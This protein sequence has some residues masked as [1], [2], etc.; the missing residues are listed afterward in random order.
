MQPDLFVNHSMMSV[1]ANPAHAGLY[2]QMFPA[3]PLKTSAQPE[4]VQNLQQYDRM[5]CISSYTQR[6]TAA[7]WDYPPEKMHVLLPPI[8]RAALRSISRCLLWHPRRR[9]QIISIGRFNPRLQNKNQ[10]I[11]IEAF[12][13]ARKIHAVLNNWL[14]MLVGHVNPDDESQ[15]YYEGCTAL[16]A[17][18]PNAVRIH[19]ALPERRL[20]GLLR[21][22]FG[23]VHGAGAFVNAKQHPE[24]CEHY[25]I[26]PAEA[27]ACGCIPLVYHQGGY[28]DF[29]EK[30]TGGL[31]Y[32]DRPSLVQGFADLA[33]LYR[34]RTA[35][36]MRRNNL[37]SVAALNQQHFTAQ[38]KAI[39]QPLFS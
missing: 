9:R 7:R 28:W 11:L 34:C 23:Y 36:Q 17:A 10:R 33:N 20:F 16:A 35:A 13:E 5:I 27:M 19:T 14:L 38:L 2:V 29:L 30:N 21:K 22:S 37:R 24:R 18:N 25:G 39:L 1:E 26:A 6:H 31:A 8:G 15:A 32:H 12:L 4:A 3:E